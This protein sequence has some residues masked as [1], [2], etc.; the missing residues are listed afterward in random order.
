M[1]EQYT[2]DEE[3]YEARAKRERAELRAPIFEEPPDE[4]N[5]EWRHGALWLGLEHGQN[6]FEAAVQY[7]TAAGIL[8]K[9][10]PRLAEGYEILAPVLFLYRHSIEAAFKGII[11]KY[12]GNIDL[13]GLYQHNLARLLDRVQTIIA[14]AGYSLPEWAGKIV[15]EFHRE[16]PKAT[17]F[18]YPQATD[19]KEIWVD[20]RR[21]QFKIDRLFSGLHKFYYLPLGA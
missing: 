10:T 7:K 2:Y 15:M 5:E 13:Y 1:S 9:N 8:T 17:G 12:D 19:Y 20:F 16:D 11:Q 14:A 3:S 4:L 21:L 6:F 18:R